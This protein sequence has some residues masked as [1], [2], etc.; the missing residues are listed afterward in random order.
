MGNLQLYSN[1]WSMFDNPWIDMVSMPRDSFEDDT[2]HLFHKHANIHTINNNMLLIIADSNIITFNTTNSTYEKITTIPQYKYNSVPPTIKA[3]NISKY[4]NK[5]NQYH[6][7]IFQS[8]F[9]S[10]ITTMYELVIHIYNECDIKNMI[11]Y[12]WNDIKSLY[13][14]N[15][16][17]IDLKCSKLLYYKHLLFLFYI[18]LWP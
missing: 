12:E 2:I 1:S 18:Q 15:D 7:I 14:K 6:F 3:I 17:L 11:T 8:N 4:Y 10:D 13:M 5:R 9:D 16:K